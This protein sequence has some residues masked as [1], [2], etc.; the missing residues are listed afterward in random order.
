MP[1]KHVVIRQLGPN[2]WELARSCN[3]CGTNCWRKKIDK[4]KPS[5]LGWACVCCAAQHNKLAHVKEKQRGKAT[6]YRKTEQAKL[7]LARYKKTGTARLCNM[8]V[9]AKAIG[10]P[11]NLISLPEKVDRCPILGITLDYNTFGKENSAEVD[12]IIPALGYVEGNTRWLSRRANRL[13]N[14]AT[15][16]E[17]LAIVADAECIRK[18]RLKS[19]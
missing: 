8:K 7:N 10:V 11:F 9:R 16:D 18:N 19:A 6:Q 2:K 3:K 15:Y 14:N 17:L 4:R 12:R 5:E 1:K 13:R